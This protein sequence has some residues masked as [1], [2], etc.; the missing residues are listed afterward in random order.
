MKKYLLIIFS[1]VIM[2][3]SLTIAKASDNPSISLSHVSAKVG[4]TVDVYVA[5]ENIEDLGGLEYGIYY[6]KASL[7][8]VNVNTYASGEMDNV[9]TKTAGVINHYIISTKGIQEDRYILCIT[10]K[11]KDGAAVG[12]TSLVL[13]VGAAYDT[14]IMPLTFSKN[15]GSV[16]IEQNDEI[17]TVE[18]F[19]YLNKY[20]TGYNDEVV[21]TL[22]VSNAYQLAT[23]VF[24]FQY[25]ANLLE[26]NKIEALT[27]FT[28]NEQPGEIVVTLSNNSKI[29]DYVSLFKLTFKVISNK[30][31]TTAIKCTQKD[32]K[33]VNQRYLNSTILTSSLGIHNDQETMDYPDLRLEYVEEQDVIKVNLIL[34]KSD[35]AAGDFKV[36]YNPM[37]LECTRATRGTALPSTVW[38]VLKEEIGQGTIQFSYINTASQKDD[39]VLLQMEFKRKEGVSGEVLITTSICLMA[40]LVA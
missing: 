29:D 31:T 39:F 3:S 21:Y 34:E 38:F 24:T 19:S 35:V 13:M 12:K 15:N 27:E 33:D 8:V 1:L 11:V 6:D 5:L 36:H 37:Q 17:N 26:F 22:N 2:F 32:L 18:F 16:T 7:E 28:T 4:N 40:V 14:D 9:N 10:F 20:E 23:G 30:N 25:D